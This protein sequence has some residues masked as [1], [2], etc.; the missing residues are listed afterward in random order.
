MILINDVQATE[1]RLLKTY[2]NVTHDHEVPAKVK[3]MVVNILPT[4]RKQFDS[5]RERK[6]AAAAQSNQSPR[7][8]AGTDNRAGIFWVRLTAITEPDAV[9]ATAAN[10]RR[11]ALPRVPSVVNVAIPY[12]SGGGSSSH[13]LRQASATS[14]LET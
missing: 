7:G 11:C 2:D 9:L 4:T 13:D 14:S 5:I 12:I 10:Q 8:G 1:H 6:W 3:S